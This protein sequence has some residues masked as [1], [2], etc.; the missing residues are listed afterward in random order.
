MKEKILIYTPSHAPWGGG[1][2]YIEHL[3]KYLSKKNKDVLMLTSRPDWFDCRCEKLQNA[4]S[5]RGRLI[6]SFKVAKEY[7]KRGYNKVILN[8]FVSIWLAPV[9]RILGFRVYALL[10]SYLHEGDGRGLGHTKI[11]ITLIKI[12]A[13]F[14]TQIF[15]ANR[16][17]IDILDKNRVIFVGNFISNWFFEYKKE[18]KKNYDFLIVARL[19]KEK[20]ISLF[21]KILSKL[22]SEYGNFNL[23][24]VGEGEEKQNIK[25]TI[26]RYHLQNVVEMRGWMDRRDLPSVYD[27]AKCFVISSY[28]EGFA[29]T[30]LE[31]HARGIPAIVTKSSGFCPEFVEGYGEKSGIV[32]DLEDTEN[33][34]FYRDIITLLDNSEKYRDICIS[35]AKEF[36]EESVLGKISDIINETD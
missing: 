8:D 24:I 18:G 27:S 32:F 23:L 16:D 34:K 19:A 5:K 26:E 11:Q 3:C 25:D 17:N 21:L 10:H 28:H 14:C 9:F 36:S 20:N 29:T 33:D 35:K 7:K 1:H 6:E 13:K 15:S 2:L 30:L 4:I 22:N 31:A 12:S